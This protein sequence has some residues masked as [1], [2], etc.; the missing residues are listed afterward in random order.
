MAS[1]GARRWGGLAR[2]AAGRATASLTSACAT[3]CLLFRPILSLPVPP[4]NTPLH[5]C[6]TKTPSLTAPLDCLHPSWT[7][8][9][10]RKDDLAPT[11]AVAGPL[12]LGWAFCAASPGR[13]PRPRPLLH[14]LPRGRP[15]RFETAAARPRR[16][17]RPR[18]GRGPTAGTS[19]MPPSSQQCSTRCLRC[20]VQRQAGAGGTGAG[21][22]GRCAARSGVR[23]GTCAGRCRSPH[24]RIMP[25]ARPPLAPRAALAQ[26]LIRAPAATPDARRPCPPT[27][28]LARS[29]PPPPPP[30]PPVQPHPT[31]QRRRSA[32]S[33]DGLRRARLSGRRRSTPSARHCTS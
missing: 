27:S 23:S 21:G 2:A 1:G 6:P 20:G 8:Y 13:L 10:E 4:I 31:P 9:C 7:A 22:G 26:S 29:P 32:S 24:A 33:S 12:F 11:A 18:T 28:A 15:A 14:H 17:Q 16:R 3:A 5:H 30:P 25:R 19:S